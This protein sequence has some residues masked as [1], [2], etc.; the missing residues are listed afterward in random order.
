MDIPATLSKFVEGKE[1]TDMVMPISY[2][3]D[4]QRVGWVHT[5]EEGI[6]KGFAETTLS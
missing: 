1:L 4:K 5:Q 3:K 2:R 6:K